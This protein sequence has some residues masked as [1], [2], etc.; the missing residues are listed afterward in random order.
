MAT[1]PLID[2]EGFHRRDFL[3]IGTAGLLGVSLPD[4]LRREAQSDGPGA[5]RKAT[6][7]IMVWLAGGPATIDMWDLKPAAPAEIRGEFRPIDTSVPGVQICEHLPKLAKVINR[8]TLVRSVNHSIPAHGPGTIYLTTGHKPTPAVV[9]PSLGSLAAKLCPAAQ[10]VPSYVTFSDAGNSIAAG[11]GYL[12][13]AYNPFEVEAAGRGKLQGVSLPTGFTVQELEDRNKLR[14]RFDAAFKTFDQSDVAASLSKFQQEA[15]DILRSDKI[16][17]AFD[18]ELEPQ[19][20][21][22]GYGYNP[23]G[24]SALV[25]RRLIEAGARFVT[26]G[27]GGWDTHGNNF[28]TLRDRLLPQLDRTLS[29]LVE[30]L[31]S[32][33]LLDSTVLYC[34]GEFGRTPRVNGA[35]GR[36]HWARSM[37]VLLAGGGIQRGHVHGATDREG[38]APATDPCSPDDICATIFHLLGIDPQHELSTT[39]GRP[40]AIFR[41]GSVIRGLLA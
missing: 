17:K 18:L 38:M 35:A 19:P 27:M 22:D 32:R 8:C 34:A 13:T 11:A 29:A 15:L 9:Y 23:L 6:S 3:K 24:Q 1:R 21:R 28:R 4:L 10:G 33:R 14:E 39:A 16:Q 36:D 40:I 26:I 37:T 30:D 41:D 7:V 25:A 12:G 20:L 5:S 2:C 31:D